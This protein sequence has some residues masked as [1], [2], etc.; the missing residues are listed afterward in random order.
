MLSDLII[1]FKNLLRVAKLKKMINTFI[2]AEL[3]A[4]CQEYYDRI[5]KIQ[6]SKFDIEKVVEHSDYK[7]IHW[8]TFINYN[9]VLVTQ[10]SKIHI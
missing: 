1:Y 7:V 4:V 9:I 6:G 5:C 8:R 3:Q 10:Y 2:I